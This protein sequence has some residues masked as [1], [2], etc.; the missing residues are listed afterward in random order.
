MAADA[1]P[2]VPILVARDIDAD[3]LRRQGR[4]VRAPRIGTNIRS[5][6]DQLDSQ[7]TI[8]RFNPEKTTSALEELYQRAITRRHVEHQGRY[9]EKTHSP[10]NGYSDRRKGLKGGYNEPR[11]APIIPQEGARIVACRW[12]AEDAFT[13]QKS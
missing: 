1:D 5:A 9:R 12:A 11:H 13:P 3:Q 4:P 7:P 10:A 6:A 2:A 8:G